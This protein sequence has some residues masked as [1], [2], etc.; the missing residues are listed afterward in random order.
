MAGPD[1]VSELV[2]HFEGRILAGELA[3]GDLLP[4]ERAISEE[5]GVG[6]STVREAISRLASLGLVRSVH[7]SGTRVEPPS[8]RPITQNYERLLRR[9]ELDLA[10]LAQVRLPLETAIAGLAARHRGDAHLARMAETQAVLADD[11]ATL[12]AHVEADLAFHAVLAEASGNPLFGLVLSPI[13]ELLIA[14]RRRTLGLHGARL[15]HE[16]HA[17]VFDAVA[18]RDPAGAAEAMRRHLEANRSH[19]TAR[20]AIFLDRDGTLIDDPGYPKDP[21]RVRL[22][23][24]AADALTA[25]R[26]AGYALVVIS[27]QAGVGRGL[28]TP[29]QAK[30]VHERFVAL[31]A[32]RGLAFDDVRYCF[33]APDDRCGCRKPSPLMLQESAAGLGIDLGRSFMIGDKESDVEAGVNAGCAGLR[34]TSWADLTAAVAHS[35]SP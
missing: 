16:H 13:Q 32:E 11:G 1:R 31:F 29:E 14:S 8:G 24:G 17:L 27:N 23:P 19:L 9:G 25:F 28:I 34:F 2:T 21:E 10:H 18:R 22:L 15:A 3:P 20:R 33:H 12:E 5:R 4:S 26:E 7:G 6:R 30:A 35:Q